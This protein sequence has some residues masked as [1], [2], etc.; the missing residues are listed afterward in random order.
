VLEDGVCPLFFPFLTA[1]KHDAALALRRRGIAAVE[2]WNYGYPA[3]AG[4]PPDVRFLRKHMLAL[5][6]HQD[7]TGAQIDYMADQ[8]AKWDRAAARGLAQLCAGS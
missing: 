4:E 5:P 2:W 3:A 1:E 6:I 8:V 7:V